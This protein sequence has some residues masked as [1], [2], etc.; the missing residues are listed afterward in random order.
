[1][2]HRRFGETGTNREPT[3]QLSGVLTPVPCIST[4]CNS[5]NKC[6]MVIYYMNFIITRK[7]K[8]I[9]ASYIYFY[10]II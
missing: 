5:T 9:G 8:H 10:V 6:T 2:E 4:I 7:S 3:Q 1:M